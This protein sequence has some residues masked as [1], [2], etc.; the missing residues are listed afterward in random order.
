VANLWHNGIWVGGRPRPKTK[1][2][3]NAKIAGQWQKWV[4]KA[5]K[6]GPKTTLWASNGNGIDWFWLKVAKILIWFFK[7][8]APH[9]KNTQNIK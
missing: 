9:K 4:A 8:R 6:R 5:N 2:E 7:V 3:A 1:E